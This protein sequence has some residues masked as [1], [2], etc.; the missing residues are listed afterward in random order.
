M[1]PET[2]SRTIVVGYDELP[3]AHAAVEGGL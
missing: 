1:A 2:I 3:T